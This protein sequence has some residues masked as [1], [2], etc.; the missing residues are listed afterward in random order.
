MIFYLISF[1]FVSWSFSEKKSCHFPLNY[2]HQYELMDIYFVFWGVVIPYRH[3]YVPILLTLFWFLSTSSLTD[4]P[5]CSTLILL[6]PCPS[7]KVNQVTKESLVGVISGWYLEWCYQ[8]VMN[9]LFLTLSLP[10][11]NFRKSLL[12]T[13][14][15]C[16]SKTHN[17]LNPNIYYQHIAECNGNKMV[18]AR[19]LGHESGAPMSGINA[20]IKGIL[21]SSL[22]SSAI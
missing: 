15:L 12:W 4:T 13:E 6:F 17:P 19:Y 3:L 16:P 14:C 9:S 5:R 18:F 20:L 10:D 1:T 21:E 22:N 11:Q 2:V 7:P 8:N